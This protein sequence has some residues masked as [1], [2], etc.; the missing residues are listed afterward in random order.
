MSAP[1]TVLCAGA[2]GIRN[3]GDDLPLIALMEG[4]RSALSGRELRFR[5]LSRHPDAEDAA[6][7][8]ATL[9]PN[10]EH[11][12]GAAARGRWFNGMNPDDDPAI[13]ANVQ[14]EIAGC[15]LLVLGAGNALL[16]QTI[17]LL[18]GPVPLMALYG[19]LARLHDR[20]V[21]L[22]GMSVGPLRTEWGRDLSRQLIG[23][24][25][26]VTVR[27]AE[28][29]ALC[30]E[31]LRRPREIHLLPD[32]TLAVAPP[33]PGRGR[34]VLRLE[35]MDVPDDRPVIALGLRDL[36]RPLGDQ[37][38][39]RQ[40]AAVLGLLERWA[41]RATFLFVPQSTYREDDDRV[42]ADRL[43]AQAPAGCRCLVV[44]KRHHPLDLVSL[45]GLAAVTVA[46]RLHGA[47]FSAIAG[48]PPVGLDYLPKMRGFL[49]HLPGCHERLALETLTADGLDAAVKHLIDEGEQRR[50]RLAARVTDLRRQAA[51]YATLAAGELSR[52]RPRGA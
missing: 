19:S 43:A 2:Y 33:E 29:F 40:E 12:S 3:A 44:H 47:V 48:T 24:A 26:V 46:S 15:D 28:S 31:L 37:A 7:L 35:N 10:L 45:Y 32:A 23:D 36:V 11:E 17:G 4:L 30:R 27:D 13:F 8:G 6:L 1:L 39:R 5:A 51:R 16:D 21:M 20:P 22:Y 42:L 14:A 9:A 50:L 25:A 34:Q 49:D 41:D 38:G 18:H 52:S